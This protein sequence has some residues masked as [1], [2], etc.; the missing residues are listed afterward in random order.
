VQTENTHEE[1]T[2]MRPQCKTNWVNTIMRNTW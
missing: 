1:H 2:V